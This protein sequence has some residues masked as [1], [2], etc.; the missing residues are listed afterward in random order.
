MIEYT[1]YAQKQIDLLFHY[2][3]TIGTRL[4]DADKLLKI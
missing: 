4:E 2:P 3:R 1:E